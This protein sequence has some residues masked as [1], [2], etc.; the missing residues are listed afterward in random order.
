MLYI[1]LTAGRKMAVEAPED[2]YFDGDFEF[3]V[4]FESE[5]DQLEN[6]TN[7][8]QYDWFQKILIYTQYIYLR[9]QKIYR[10]MKVTIFPYN[11]DM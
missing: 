2:G 3:D 9:R 7:D 11:C 1:Y 4:D 5:K 6:D 10:K 8:D